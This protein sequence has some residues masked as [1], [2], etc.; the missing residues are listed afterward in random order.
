MTNP[1]GTDPGDTQAV[2][3]DITVT[4]DVDTTVAVDVGLG[5]EAVGTD[6]SVS[7]EVV[8]EE[9]INAGFMF[10]LDL[11]L[12]E[13]LKGMKVYDIESGGV[14]ANAKA[15][16]PV[17]VYF[18]NGD[19]DVQQRQWPF[20][21][22]TLIGVTRAS[23]REHRGSNPILAASYTIGGVNFDPVLN[24]GADQQYAMDEWPIPYDFTWQ[25]TSHAR[26]WQ[27]DRQIMMNMEM[28]DKLP[29][30][31]G[32]LQVADTVRILTR[33][34]GPTT[35]DVLQGNPAKRIYRKTWTAQCTAEF[36]R[37]QLY[38]LSTIQHLD[39]GLIDLL[40]PS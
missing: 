6:T 40:D 7:F 29:T 5:E 33:E 14:R 31:F 26:T 22:I 4:A 9:A 25:I 24:P 2:G 17:F 35:T 27:H 13:H 20:L 34:G 30:R 8:D 15:G 11:A 19:V 21:L 18:A 16:R 1:D 3:N 10:D 28:G 36:Y 12:L 37:S 39:L 23:S 38:R 32:S